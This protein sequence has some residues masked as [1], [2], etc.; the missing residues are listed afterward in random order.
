M[1]SLKTI[2]LGILISANIIAQQSG[3]VYQGNIYEKATGKGLQMVTVL[4]LSCDA[5]PDDQPLHYTTTRLDGA[6]VLTNIQPG[7]YNVKIS[8]IGYTN[9]AD[10]FEIK[11]GENLNREF[12]L[13]EAA[14]PLEQ[15]IVSGLRRDKPLRQIIVPMSVISSKE[16]DRT[17]ANTAADLLGHEPGI[18]L[19]RDGIWA[20]SISIRG[21]SDQRIITLIDGNRLETA[22]D[23]AGGLSMIDI[24][25]V[26]RIEVIKGA[27]STLYGSGGLGGVLNVVTKNGYFSEGLYASGS[28]STGYQAVNH[29]FNQSLQFKTGAANWYLKLGG[30]MR[31]AGNTMSPAGELP[32]SQFHDH[33]F[34]ATFGLKLSEKR[35]FKI[36]F[37]E[38]VARNVGISG[39]RA[40]PN[41][42]I[43]TYPIEMRQMG[44][45]D[46]TMLDITD[47]LKKLSVKYYI[48]YILRDVELRPAPSQPTI[49]NPIGKHLTNGFQIQSDWKFG[50]ANHLIAGMDIW[51]RFLQTSRETTY[52]KPITD[53]LGNITGYRDS[54][55][56]DVPI[57]NSYFTDLGCYV[58]DEFPLIDGKLNFTLGARTDFI[59]VTND[60]ALDPL[61][62]VVNGVRNDNPANQRI[63]FEK[64]VFNDFSASGNAGL[65]FS[66]GSGFKVAL[67]LA[68]SFRAPSLE[69][70]FKY[71]ALPSP[72]QLG[73]PKLKSEDGYSADLGLQEITKNFNVSIDFFTNRMNNLI[74]AKPGKFVYSLSS[75]P[76]TFDTLPAL[77][78]A[79][80]NKAFLYGFDL[81]LESH[82]S[83][84]F[85]YF[86]SSF[87][88]GLDLSGNTNLPSIAPFNGELGVNY[89]QPGE[90]G[91]T[92]SAYGAIKQEKA[93]ASEKITPGFIVVNLQLNSAFINLKYLRLQ[94]FAGI[95]NLLNHDYVYFLSTNRGIVRSEPGRNLYLKMNV[96]F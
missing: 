70:R 36:N 39:G 88:R 14:F 32:N 31:S 18:S 75:S 64:G 37:Q 67:N 66:P 41:A 81:K 24:S 33:N 42:A 45:V 16:I 51:Q 49:I 84:I 11:E 20:T 15:I 59:K 90:F 23:I 26:E 4:L 12:S 46:Y 74:V 92:A 63:T 86:K 73:D 35:E 21:L 13:T 79:N 5:S 89:N 17:I 87:V 40:F 6:F 54:I 28:T 95:D 10:S 52:K 85:T 60:Q 61:Y 43:A 7:C 80:I 29:Q 82:F 78:N 56:G 91:V 22:T 53:G 93:A 27:G 50:Y 96:R 62:F 3:S 48:Q 30:M 69:E 19:V 94:F 9:L 76:S 38:F 71:I 2:I 44:S 1:K 68:R 55:K 77:I 72:I 65:Q 58:Q 57:P 25:D 8:S 34:S 47:H 83:N